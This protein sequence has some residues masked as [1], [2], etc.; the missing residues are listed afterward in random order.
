MTDGN[1]HGGRPDARA[2]AWSVL[3]LVSIADPGDEDFAQAAR[4]AT[5]LQ[6]PDDLLILATRHRMVPT[7]ADFLRRADLMSIMPVGFRH[8]L[9]H[10][11]EWNRHK[12]R[13][14]LTEAR[15]IE[16]ALREAGLAVAFNKGIVCQATL[17]DGRGVRSF[18]DIDLM[19]L[20]DQREAVQQVL[21]KFGYETGKTY[22][23]KQGCLVDL[24]RSELL[25]YRL[26]PDHLPHFFRIDSASGI[27]YFNIDVAFS[28]TWYGSNWQI[29]MEEVLASIQHVPVDPARSET[30]LPALDSAHGFLFLVLH[31]FR[32][33]WFQRT[34][35]EG[36]ERIS[37]FADV[38]KF[39]R[40]VGHRH[41][42]EIR[43]LS[44]TYG[45]YPA[46]AWICHH[47]D[48]L[49]GSTIISALGADEYCD[50]V[51]LHSAAA[52]DGGYL[53]WGGDM[54]SRLRSSAPPPLSVITEPPYAAS[55]KASRS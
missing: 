10:T 45:L 9:Q 30:T 17:Y 42:D 29:P 33:C 32:E 23:H 37:Q 41:A 18:S 21:L 3:E 28:L 22:D 1:T 20:P 52:T 15:R 34:I 2:D 4:L 40:R 7:L 47:V 46:I 13:I 44:G 5:Q 50:Q 12:T 26:Y 55:A 6:T 24:L 39:W 51:W 27:P 53:A 8:L 19:I 48:S 31:L 36:S 25:L 49:F 14:L 35:V 16:S 11:L 54:R 43:V 38:L